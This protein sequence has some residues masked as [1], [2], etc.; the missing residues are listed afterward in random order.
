MKIDEIFMIVA[1]FVSLILGYFAKKNNFI[2]TELIPLQNLIIG[3]IVTIIEWIITKSFNE[4]IILSGVLAGGTYDI[5]HNL[6]KIVKN[7]E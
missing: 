1:F 4:A 2:K 5:F 6:K 7:N 3:L